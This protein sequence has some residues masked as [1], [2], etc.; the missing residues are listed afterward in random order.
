[1]TTRAYVESHG[2]VICAGTHFCDDDQRGCINEWIAL[3]KGLDKT[4]DPEAY[5]C[6]RCDQVACEGHCEDLHDYDG[7]DGFF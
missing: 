6:E 3:A 4:D 2:G 7:D 5:R 1:M